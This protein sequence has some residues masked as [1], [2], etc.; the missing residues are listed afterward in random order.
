MNTFMKLFGFNIHNKRPTT[1]I[2][3]KEKF[4][5]PAGKHK[6]TY[7]QCHTTDHRILYT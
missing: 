3:I 5:P 1:I 6:M 4:K 2:V 7:H